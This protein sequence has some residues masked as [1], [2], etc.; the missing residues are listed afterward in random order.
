MNTS[1]KSLLTI[2]MPITKM[3]NK[4]NNLEQVLIDLEQAPAIELRIVHDIQDSYTSQ[5]LRTLLARFTSSK[6]LL[7][8][9]EFGSAGKAR[10]QG[11]TDIKTEFIMFWDSDDLPAVKQIR[12]F[13]NTQN[14][15]LHE[16]IVGQFIIIDPQGNVVKE[17]HSRNIFSFALNPG[18]WRCIFKTAYLEGNNFP[19]YKVAEDQIFIGKYLQHVSRIEFVEE[20]FYAYQVGDT[21][22]TTMQSENLKYLYQSS[23]ATLNLILKVRIK[24]I[25]IVF[26]MAT[27]QFATYLFRYSSLTIA[28]WLNRRLKW[29]IFRGK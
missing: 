16:L 24:F 12:D 22:Q 17:H 23:L 19:A 8:E 10:N 2:I 29:L 13:L 21:N 7:I 14:I 6:I 11:L 9:G 25:P 4:L 18:I 20:C 28:R 15:S 27:R 3:H 5:S 26:I 1:G